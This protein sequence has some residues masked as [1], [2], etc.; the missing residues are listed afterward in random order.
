M[1]AYGMSY[2]AIQHA[3]HPDP[4]IVCSDFVRFLMYRTFRR[5]TVGRVHP[6]VPLTLLKGVSIGASVNLGRAKT[7]DGREGETVSEGIR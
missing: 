6:G 2:T 4:V 5:R 1:M 3:E 7:K